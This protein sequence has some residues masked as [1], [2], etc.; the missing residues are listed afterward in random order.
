MAQQFSLRKASMKWTDER[1]G[2]VLEVVGALFRSCGVLDDTDLFFPAN[3]ILFHCANL[4]DLILCHFFSPASMRV[5]KYFCYEGSFLAR[6]FRI[7]T[8]EL[9]GIRKIQHSQSAK[10]VFF[11][12]SFLLIILLFLGGTEWLCL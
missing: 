8:Q 6:L 1:A 10:C 7:R 3:L 5:V 9:R 2:R 11:S 12:L 4:T